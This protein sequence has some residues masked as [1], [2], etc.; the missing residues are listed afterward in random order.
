MQEKQA[1]PKGKARKAEVQAQPANL[2]HGAKSLVAK[3]NPDDFHTG[4]GQSRPP[5]RQQQDLS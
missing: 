2:N 4:E 1:R 3:D 5:K